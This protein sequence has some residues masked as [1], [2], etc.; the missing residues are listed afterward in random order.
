VE[1]L[2][3]GDMYSI[4]CSACGRHE[5][6][7]VSRTLF[8]STEPGPALVAK[9]AEPISAA[10]FKVVREECK[11]AAAMSLEK[12]RKELTSEFGFWLGNLPEY[13]VKEIQEK[14]SAVGIFLEEPPHEDS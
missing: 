10:A 11:H 3:N 7:T 9:A 1:Y 2:E 8:P 6:G 14:F 13:R 5:E 4:R 12:L